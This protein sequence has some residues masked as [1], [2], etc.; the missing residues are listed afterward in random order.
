VY[1]SCLGTTRATAGS[2]AAQEKLDLGLN[3]DLAKRA[4]ADG[5]EVVRA[6]RGLGHGSPQLIL[7]SSGGSSS[8]S[9][10]P[11]TKMKGK[12]EDAVKA[13]DFG[14]CIILQPGVLLGPRYAAPF[15]T[16]LRNGALRAGTRPARQSTWPRRCSVGSGLSGY[17]TAC[18][19]STAT[20]GSLIRG[21]RRGTDSSVGACIA[22]L[23]ANP[24]GDKVKVMS[25]SE[26][27]AAAQQWREA[28]AA[29]K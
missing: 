24:P 29:A 21:A 7:V 12:L 17:R 19:W 1:V 26:I 8:S 11:Y 13:M 15:A 3:T 2:F 16:Q 28:N 27:I 6:L 23:A 10:F 25:N 22:H 18:S 20:S 4:K 14:S 9:V 5:A